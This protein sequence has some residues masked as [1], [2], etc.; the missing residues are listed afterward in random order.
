VSRAD[1]CASASVP[2]LLGHDHSELDELLAAFFAAA[3]KDDLEASFQALDI[4]WARLAMH[5]RA[6]HLHL[7]PT[8]LVAAE[9]IERRAKDE[10]STPSA[11]VV[12]ET[13]ARLRVDHDFF[14][15]EL[16]AAI[17]QLRKE[18]ER[19]GGTT[20]AVIAEV[21]KKGR[22]VD[23]RLRRHN[24]LEETQVYRWAEALLSQAEC[25]NLN[26][27]MNRELANLPERLVQ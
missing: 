7:F 21:E 22:A 3:E 5:I 11:Q 16:T 20:S 14:M 8:L 2:K 1:D 9:K 19:A 10:A 17:A 12:R 26:A 24:T 27:M 18:R 15:R 13:I 6:E 25:T 23:E 4:F